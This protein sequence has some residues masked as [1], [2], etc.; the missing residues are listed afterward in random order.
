MNRLMVL[1][2]DDSVDNSIVEIGG[3]NKIIGKGV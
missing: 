1:A 3:S 2:E